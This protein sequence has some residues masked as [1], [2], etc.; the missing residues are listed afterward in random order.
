MTEEMKDWPLPELELYDSYRTQDGWWEM[1]KSDGHVWFF[2]E[3]RYYFLF[4]ESPRG[5]GLCFGE[6]ELTGNFPRWTFNS[7]DE[8]FAAKLF[9]GKTILECLDSVRGWQPG[10]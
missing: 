9:N 1:L 8:F 3:G 2:V 5:F 10:C 4:P 6:D 7:A